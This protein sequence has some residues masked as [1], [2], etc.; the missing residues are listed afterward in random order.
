M[1]LIKAEYCKLLRHSIDATCDDIAKECGVTKQTISNY[2]R[3]Y[4]TFND[5]KLLSM[6]ILYTYALIKC[7]ERSEEYE[8]F[9]ELYSK[10]SE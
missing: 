9:S 2:E 1:K 6:R 5:E 8:V 10:Y 3:K 7:A 4:K